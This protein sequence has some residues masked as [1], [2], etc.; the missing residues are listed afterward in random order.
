VGSLKK[1]GLD[2]SS[3]NTLNPKL[4]YCSVTG[5]GQDGPRKHQTGYDFM[6]QGMSGLMSIT[7]NPDQSFKVGVA[8][9]DLLSGEIE[10]Y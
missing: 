5:F 8:I 4:I 2:Y 9:S 10:Q 3:L 6:I 7:G 1:F